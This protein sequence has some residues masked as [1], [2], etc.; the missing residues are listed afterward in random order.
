MHAIRNGRIVLNDK[1]LD[2]CALYGKKEN[3][4]RVSR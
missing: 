1:I 2:G 3:A 4:G